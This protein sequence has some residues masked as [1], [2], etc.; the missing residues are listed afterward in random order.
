MPGR[1]PPRVCTPPA[2]RR[3]TTPR[4]SLAPPPPP[5]APPVRWRLLSPAVPPVMVPPQVLVRLGV[6]ATTMAPG[7]VGKA[8]VKPTLVMAM[9]AFGLVITIVSVLTPFTDIGLGLNVFVVVGDA[10]VRV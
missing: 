3:A 10:G 9:S 1:P 6:A 2:G 7:T 4:C 5:T 8:S